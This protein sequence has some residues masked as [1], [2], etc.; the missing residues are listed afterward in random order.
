MIWLIGNAGMLG[1]EL[2]AALARSGFNC[3]GTG[4]SVDILDPEALGSFTEGKAIDWIVNCAAYTDVDKAEDADE[5]EL[6]ARLNIEGPGNI[7]TVAERIGAKLFHISTDYVFDGHGSRPYRE[8]GPVSPSNVYGRTK[9]DG[10]A[11]VRSLC[12]EHLILRTAWLYGKQG[13]NFVY[14]ML[15]QMRAQDRIQVVAD[16]RGTP[17]W[18]ADLASAIVTILRR[19]ET[20]FGTYH[21]TDSGVASWYDF[22][23]EIEKLGLE[24]GL[25]GHY[26]I[27]EPITTALFSSRAKRPA[28]SVLSTEK[29]RKDYEVAIPEWRYSLASFIRTLTIDDLR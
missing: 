15:R 18:A 23:L 28:Y 5:S 22:A 9:V 27:I 14:T 26:C 16:Q 10:E 2:S 8:D 1:T 13:S 25:L 7:A 11:C 4:R 21:F 17:T 29:I 20:V 19:P 3:V 24:Y 6:C 12:P